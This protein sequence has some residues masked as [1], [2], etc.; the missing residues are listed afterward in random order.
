MKLVLTEALKCMN[1]YEGMF[2]HWGCVHRMLAVGENRDKIKVWCGT[3]QELRP[4]FSLNA[5]LITVS[6]LWNHGKLV[7]LD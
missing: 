4:V 6:P 2:C 5:S 3:P 7:M 1:I